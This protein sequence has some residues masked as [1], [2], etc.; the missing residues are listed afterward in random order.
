MSGGR[1]GGAWS[2]GCGAFGLL[3]VLL[4]VGLVVWLSSRVVDDTGHVTNAHHT[5]SISATPSSDL[6][7][8]ETIQVSGRDFTPNA[9]VAIF[10][11]ARP[12]TTPLC[13]RSPLN[14][15]EL[16]AD[17]L[18]RF[19]SALRVPRL[20]RTKGGTFDCASPESRCEVR[21]TEPSS[22]VFATGLLTFGS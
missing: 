7:E 9:Q 22:S 16:D 10:Q 12:H 14:T 6:S 19:N 20:L 18:G 4:G 1:G 13:D 15:V 8:G 3:S 2:A 11:C 17:E 21:A 5:A